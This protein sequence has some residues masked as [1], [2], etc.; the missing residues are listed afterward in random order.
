MLISEGRGL[1]GKIPHRLR[2]EGPFGTLPTPAAPSPGVNQPTSL[3]VHRPAGKERVQDAT[4]A[5]HQAREMLHLG[6]LSA[7]LGTLL[8]KLASNS[9][10]YVHITE[11]S[12]A[13]PS[14]HGCVCVCEC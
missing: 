6:T 5:N 1:S 12:V 9:E 3:R 2:F 13:C 4:P 7:S 11:V 10:N 14:S 8:F